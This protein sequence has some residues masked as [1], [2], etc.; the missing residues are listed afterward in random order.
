MQSFPADFNVEPRGFQCFEAAGANFV[1]CFSLS[2]LHLGFSF[3]GSLHPAISS[4]LLQ[5]VSRDCV[6]EGGASRGAPG[7]VLGAREAFSWSVSQPGLL[8]GLLVGHSHAC[9]DTALL[10][11][12]GGRV[13][14]SPH[15]AVTGRTRAHC[16]SLRSNPC[17][18]IRGLLGRWQHPQ[19]PEQRL[20]CTRLPHRCA[21]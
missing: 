5:A 18:D 11:Q 20:A 14:P 4:L 8:G 3:C 7:E 1:F 9:R 10:S 6:W 17:R 13:L 16:P 19:G 2:G 21:V 15:A 12:S